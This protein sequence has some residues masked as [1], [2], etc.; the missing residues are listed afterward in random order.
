MV[1]TNV[2]LCLSVD[3]CDHNKD[4]TLWFISTKFYTPDG[5]KSLK[6]FQ[7]GANFTY[8]KKD[9]SWTTYYFL[10]PIKTNESW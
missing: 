6:P 3:V 10:N 8:L 9:I 5:K 7:N 2:C 1:Y 4:Q